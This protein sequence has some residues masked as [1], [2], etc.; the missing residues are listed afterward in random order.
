MSLCFT[1]KL[2][3]NL[4]RMYAKLEINYRKTLAVTQEN[5]KFMNSV[6]NCLLTNK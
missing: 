1:K 4:G 2:K 6:N 5:V 3:K